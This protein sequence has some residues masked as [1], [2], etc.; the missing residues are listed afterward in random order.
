MAPGILSYWTNDTISGLFEVWTSISPFTLIS[1]Y[2][3]LPSPKKR[4]A[5]LESI[6]SMKSCLTNISATVLKGVFLRIEKHFIESGF[7]LMLIVGLAFIMV[8]WIHIKAVIQILVFENYFKK[9]ELQCGHANE[10]KTCSKTS[11]SVFIFSSSPFLPSL[12]ILKGRT[13][14]LTRLRALS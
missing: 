10:N 6:Y 2:L 8:W 11:Y 1:D 4:K 9:H 12:T 3:F 13:P 7:S 5:V 14:T